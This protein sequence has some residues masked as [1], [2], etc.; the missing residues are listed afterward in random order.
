[1]KVGL[2]IMPKKE[3]LD[4]Q[5]RAVLES[6]KHHKYPLEN[7]RIGKY[8]EIELPEDIQNSHE[9]LIHKMAKDLLVNELVETY[10]WEII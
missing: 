4:S 9:E 8:I 7:C 10:E 2:K 6:L 3:V 5:G 1:M